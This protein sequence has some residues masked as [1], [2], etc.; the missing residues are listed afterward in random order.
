MIVLLAITINHQHSHICMYTCTCSRAHTHT[1]SAPRSVSWNGRNEISSNVFQKN[2]ADIIGAAVLLPLRT[3][4]SF[5]TET[6][7]VFRNK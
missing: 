5:R 7:T 6:V 1:A 4:F 2:E 3:A